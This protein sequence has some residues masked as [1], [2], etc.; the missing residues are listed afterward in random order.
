MWLQLY[1]S[2]GQAYKGNVIWKWHINCP[3][4]KWIESNW[5]NDLRQGCPH[6]FVCALLDLLGHPWFKESKNTGL[7]PSSCWSRS[8]RTIVFPHTLSWLRRV[9]WYCDGPARVS[10]S[11]RELQRTKETQSAQE[12]K[13]PL[14]LRLYWEK[15]GKICAKDFRFQP[16]TVLLQG[17]C[18]DEGM[19]DYITSA[20]TR[21]HQRAHCGGVWRMWPFSSSSSSSADRQTDSLFF[22]KCCKKM[23]KIKRTR[24]G[25]LTNKSVKFLDIYSF[26]FVKTT[27]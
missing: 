1:T 6:F 4:N 14:G 8:S 22:I 25:S 17:S 21:L 5:I 20:G 27:K 11:T 3:V 10:A 18:D 12:G 13:T 19:L 2:Q 7:K 26:M 15:C 16:E 24:Y 9:L 23:K